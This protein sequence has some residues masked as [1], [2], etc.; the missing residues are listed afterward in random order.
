VANGFVSPALEDLLKLLRTPLSRQ[1][2]FRIVELQAASD[3]A[4]HFNS[5]MDG[6]HPEGSERIQTL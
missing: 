5:R 1:R 4:D 3:A 6:G 2:R